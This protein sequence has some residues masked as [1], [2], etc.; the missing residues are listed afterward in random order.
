MAMI[1][2]GI[3][4]LDWTIWQQGPVASVMLGD[5]G[6]EV[7][8]IEQRGS[9]DPAR[10]MM[11]LAGFPAQVAERNFYFENNNRNK[12]S[13]VVDLR[14][15]EGKKIVYE[16]V[17]KSDVFVQN[18]RKGVAAR[19]GLDYANLFPY[20]P[21]L[22]YASASGWGPEG[23]D[24]EKPSYDY[25]TMARS[26]IMTM[27]GEPDMPPLFVQGTIG[28][29][30]GAVMTAFGVLAALL[31]RERTGIGQELHIS[32]L[33]SMV[34]LQGLNVAM[35]LLLGFEMP[36]MARG[37]VNNP[38][39]NHYLCKDDKW[40]ALAH[41]Q[42]DRH[43]RTL[44]RALGMEHLEKD[45]KFANMEAREK[46]AAEMIAILDNIFATKTRDEWIEILSQSGEL[47]FS[48]VNTIS[49]V[50]SD[51]Q[52]LANDYVTD[53]NH[54]VWGKIQVVGSPVK[55]SKTPAAAQREAPEFG[56]HT[57]EILTEILGYT[58]DDI[59]KLKDEEVI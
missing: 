8:K 38:F 12:K 23:P 36:R 20:N 3:R 32:G 18:F 14:R 9:G 49:D 47:I 7:I 44:C 26:G 1:L 2:E 33:G 55:F 40:I 43:W 6:A 57:E 56:Q 29:Q 37:K 54:P 27:V 45:P 41:I 17:K 16:L 48:C 46:N 4:V 13:L 51:P 22:I 31:A 59:V 35:K 34:W 58:W 42:V 39:Y 25:T 30:M 10:G 19:L 15:E 24:A 28:D 21:G 5:L 52:V 50:V 53:F 11:K